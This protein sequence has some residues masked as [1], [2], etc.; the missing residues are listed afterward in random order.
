[1]GRASLN[2]GEEDS[3]QVEYSLK[4]Y[5]SPPH[6]AEITDCYF[7]CYTVEQHLPPEATQVVAN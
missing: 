2:L 6:L 7:L 1:M 5:L 4:V 3:F